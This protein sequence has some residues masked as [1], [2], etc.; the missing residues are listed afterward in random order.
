MNS[1]GPRSSVVPAVIAAIL[2][3]IITT[4]LTVHLMGPKP[5]GTSANATAATTVFDRVLKSGTIRCGYVIYPPGLLKNPNTKAIEGVFPETLAAASK[6][7]GFKVEWVE[8]VGWGSMIEGLEADRYDM[9]C[10][11]VWANASRAKRAD[12]TVP[13]FYSGIGIYTR[14]DDHRFDADPAALNSPSVKLAT[15][16]GEM[17]DIISHQD[18]PAASRVSLPQLSD[19]S[20]L[21]LGLK[22]KKADATFVEP[23]IAQ[24]FLASNPG[25]IRNMAVERPIRIFPNT[26]MVKKGETKLR[27]MMDTALMEVLNSGA[28]DKILQRY[29][30]EPGT[31]YPV[32]LPYRADVR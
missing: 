23:Y 24:Q 18:F 1:Q 9:I 21:L 4:A 14:T 8:E 15:I 27:T 31:F 32:A 7:L 25:T 2:A 3:A 29:S 5:A 13:L 22:D 26:M 30:K 6:A 20:Q 17:S 28:V 11:P 10:S 19:N 12:F 16:D